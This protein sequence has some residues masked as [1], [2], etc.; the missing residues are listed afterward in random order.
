MKAS[1]RFRSTRS[2]FSM[3]ELL[4][5]IVL[6][7]IIFAAMLP[8][9]ANALKKT[10]GDNFRITATNIAQ[11]RIE[12]VRQ[13][14]YTQIVA[15]AAHP[16]TTPNMYNDT[17][18]NGMF[19]TTYTPPA[20]NKMYTI[21]YTVEDHGNYKKVIVAVTW[22]EAMQNGTSSNKTTTMQ[23]IIMDPTAL[24]VTSTSN[25]YPAPSGGYSLTVAFKNYT[26]VSSA[27]VVVVQVYTRPGTPSPIPTRTMTVSPTL[28][29][30]ASSTTVTWTGLTGGL[31]INYMVTCHTTFGNSYTGPMFHL[32]SNGWMKF[33][34]N[35]GGS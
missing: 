24:S 1:S 5:T 11:D 8:V 20:S 10:S 33:D 29:P 3:V 17:W 18:A 9:F 16:T 7:G 35:P 19:D 22:S 14:P 31:G 25:P 32:L 6:A 23:T 21:G 2:G 34:T 26:E 27:G 30:N 4:V 28:R 13:L 15:D 12:K